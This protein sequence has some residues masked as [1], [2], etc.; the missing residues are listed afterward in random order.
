MKILVTGSKGQ[1]GTELMIQ[2]SERGHEM[3]GYDIPELDISDQKKI[4][5][6][7]SNGHFDIVIN[8]AAYTAVD[9][10]ETEHEKAEN[11]NAK[12]P[13]Y[14]AEECARTKT[15]LI[16]VSTDYV[17]NGSKKDPYT[18]NDLPDPIGVYGTTKL[19]GEK[20]VQTALKHHIIVRTAWVYGTHG[21]N[22]VRT[23]LALGKDREELRVV[24]DQTGCPTDSFD[25]AAALLT[26]AESAINDDKTDI[27]GIYHFCGAGKVTWH[28]F[29]EAIF[30][31]AK[32]YEALKVKKVHAITT[33][34]YP[35]PAKRPS[36]SVLDCNKFSAAFGMSIPEW[37]QSLN[38]MIKRL[39]A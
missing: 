3:S 8:A 17:F 4:S 13:L 30:E 12:G 18:E 2:G 29:A 7:I 24:S 21:K 27:W 19:K 5:D 28:G 33:A 15:P 34:E 38:R 22:F 20:A 6:I 9:M 39:Y 36:N 37:R 35:T 1:L 32:K 16:H 31:E 10:A 11:V 26:A 23:M 25:L 14:I